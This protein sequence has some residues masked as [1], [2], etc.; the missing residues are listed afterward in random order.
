MARMRE[1]AHK[2]TTGLEEHIVQLEERFGEAKVSA[3]VE[4]EKVEQQLKEL[5]QK[6]R[7]S[8]IEKFNLK[9]ELEAAKKRLKLV[10]TQGCTIM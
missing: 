1:D 5:R 7:S 8:F 4:V 9:R 3:R 6:P 2:V 10:E